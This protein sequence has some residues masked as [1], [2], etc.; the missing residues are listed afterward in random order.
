MYTCVE[1]SA[2]PS[3]V[4]EAL[5]GPDSAKWKEAMQH[6]TESIASNNVWTLVESPKDRKLISSKW[7]FKRK[8]GP[9]GSVYSY[10]A[11]LLLKDF[12]RR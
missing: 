4:E 7:V 6:E 11:H 3:S 10:K 2:E 5:S 9:D 8:I 12:H 1:E